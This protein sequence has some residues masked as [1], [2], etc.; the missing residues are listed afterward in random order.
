MSSYFLVAPIGIEAL[1]IQGKSGY[2]CV[3]PMANFRNLPYC[4]R[5][6][7]STPDFQ[8]NNPNAIGRDVLSGTPYISEN[9]VSQPFQNRNFLLSPGIHLHWELPKALRTGEHKDQSLSFPTTPNCWLVIRKRGETIEA[10]WIVESDYLCDTQNRENTSTSVCIPYPANPQ[11]GKYQPFRYLGR[12]LSLADWLKH[13]RQADEY[14]GRHLTAIGYGEPAF[15]AFYPNCYSVFG[16]HDSEPGDL[17]SNLSYEVIGWH[18][19]IE[20]DYMRSLI[21][22]YL[23]KS[24]RSLNQFIQDKI[25]WKL[26]QD[27][28]K[29]Q[30]SLQTLY[31]GCLEFQPHNSEQAQENKPELDSVILANSGTEALSS[32]IAHQIAQKDNNLSKFDIENQLEAIQL[33]TS[34]KEEADNLDNKLQ[35]A[36]HEK[37]FVAHSS[38]IVWNIEKIKAQQNDYLPSENSKNFLLD[39]PSE[40]AD[41][42]KHLNQL[43]ENYNTIQYQLES[44]RQQIF[45]DWYKYL[46]CLYPF[47]DDFNRYPSPQLVKNFISN[48]E[49]GKLKHQQ[50]EFDS[51]KPDLEKCLTN[52][53]HDLDQLNKKSFAENKSDAKPQ[54]YQ[55]KSVP[56][57][58]YW[59]P[60]E[61]VIM[62]VF[63][64]EKEKNAETRES[65][66]QDFVE[67]FILHIEDE[68]IEKSLF[69]ETLATHLME[70]IQKRPKRK[71]QFTRVWRS[72]PWKPF[73][74]EWE[75]QITGVQNQR[76]YFADFIKQYYQTNDAVI[77]F[78][79]KFGITQD[80]N[81]QK[82]AYSG[83]SILTQ[84]AADQ[85]KQQIEAF[86]T[87]KSFFSQFCK[88][89]SIEPNRGWLDKHIEDLKEWIAQSEVL[90]PQE[91]F[92]N[93]LLEI[94]E[95]FKD[96]QCLSQALNGFN[97]ALL[98][99]K[100]TLQLPIDDPIGFEGNQQFVESVRQAVQ[101]SIISAPQPLNFFNPIRS[102]LLKILRLRLVDTFGRVRD[103]K[104][105]Q[106]IIPEHL[107]T[108]LSLENA[109]NLPPR[110]VQPARLHFRWLSGN[111]DHINEEASSHPSLNPIC[112]WLLPDRIDQTLEVYNTE[113]YSLGELEIHQA[114]SQRWRSAP[115]SE[116]AVKS[117]DDIPNPHL[118]R[119]VSY[120][121]ASEDQ[122]LENF[123]QSLIQAC[124][125]IDLESSDCDPSLALLMG[126]PI[127]VV[128]ASLNLQLQGL[129]AINQDWAIF[130]RELES[131]RKYGSETSERQTNGFTNVEFP[132]YL[133]NHQSFSDGLVGYWQETHNNQ[134]IVLSEVVYIPL[135]NVDTNNDKQKTEKIVKCRQPL[136][137]TIQSPPQFITAL[138]D[139]RASIQAVSGILPT[140]SIQ[141]PSEFYANIINNISITF[142]A[143]PILSA[144]TIS[145]PL[146]DAL[147]CNWSWLE[148]QNLNQWLEVSSRGWLERDQ[149][150]QHF[151]QIKSE[152][153]GSDV[154]EY[155]LKEEIGWLNKSNE[156]QYFIVPQNKRKC[157]KLSQP[158]SNFQKHIEILLDSLAYK[159]RSTTT[160]ATFSPQLIRE[161]W[162]KLQHFSQD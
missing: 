96:I 94:N 93:R 78:Q 6:Y 4:D 126:Q 15:A 154:L 27:I 22:E 116:L 142:L 25:K 66:I 82:D 147:D 67:C 104:C 35:Q 159:V 56:A 160:D 136:Y 84:Y 41:K 28:E 130:K 118:K 102:G 157:Q 61:P 105:D 120:L 23:S 58:R 3:E 50:A 100:Q 45:A 98:G 62:A 125:Q 85:H 36:R 20:Y 161:G 137:Q 71:H 63:K 33:L 34:L 148:Q 132:I 131:F 31:Y 128:R 77:D 53:K 65:V 141:I 16:C 42:L 73:L 103:L 29:I 44:Q 119:V 75:I 129:P 101:D 149:F 11:Q 74:L 114:G 76:N 111:P 57:P 143:A 138:I 10:K 43:Q 68:K 13:D 95:S 86:F 60:N 113:G 26:D 139:P 49:I 1:H 88:D 83:R 155:L 108:S 7:N 133:G 80:S 115:G 9:I 107:K 140:K 51:L 152:I 72:Q 121:N 48:S 151:N 52:L 37:E 70:S 55:L 5:N 99:R 46:I 18:S 89:K 90:K 38:G 21:S 91:Q 146:A 153:Q 32:Y 2:L 122:F 39:L 158:Y 17:N 69:Y 110:I 12:Q 135:E 144:N 145:I 123:V 112:G 109:A 127:A 64:L 8:K 40:I 54:E 81:T 156:I 117:V 162:L 47:V 92:F 87:Q 59:Q 14:W 150:I 134:N 30:T 79:L 106:T 24:E 19:Q 124:E 97:Q